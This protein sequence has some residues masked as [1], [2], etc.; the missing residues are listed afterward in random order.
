MNPAYCIIPL[1]LVFTAFHKYPIC[2]I[3]VKNNYCSNCGTVACLEQG[4]KAR[5]LTIQIDKVQSKN[6]TK[7]AIN[8]GPIKKQV[9]YILDSI[10]H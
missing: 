8:Y 6:R 10:A 2:Y 5:R 7:Q 1:S 4:R 3:Q 9:C